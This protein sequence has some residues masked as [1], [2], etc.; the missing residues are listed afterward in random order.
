[1]VLLQVLKARMQDH[2]TDYQLGNEF[3]DKHF[4]DTVHILKRVLETDQ[5]SGEI[6]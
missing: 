1:M 5:R 2:D 6:P 3:T 4:F